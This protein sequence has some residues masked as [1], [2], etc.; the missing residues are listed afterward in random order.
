MRVHIWGGLVALWLGGA[1]VSCGGS[2]GAIECRDDTSC[3]RFPGGDCLVNPVTGNQFCTYPDGECPSGMRWS[4]LD[5]EDSISGT[6]VAV[7][8]GDDAGADSSVALDAG[9]DAQVAGTVVRLTADDG[10]AGDGFGH[11]AISGDTIAIGAPGDDDSAMNSGAVYIF[12]WNEGQ[13]VWEQTRKLKAGDPTSGAAFG[14]AVA[15]DGDVLVV[16]AA[17]VSNVG[18]A[19]VFERNGSGGWIQT[20]KLTSG[21][22]Y[23]TFGGAVATD[24]TIVVVGAPGD[25]TNAPQSGAVYAYRRGVSSWDF[26]GKLTDP[27]S[28]QDDKLGASVAVTAQWIVTSAPGYDVTAGFNDGA[29][30]VFET[31]GQSWLMKPRLVFPSSNGGGGFGSTVSV[32]GN[33]VAA[34]A[35]GAAGAGAVVLFGR[36]AG[37]VWEPT[38]TVTASNST[39]GA[40]FGAAVA[41]SGTTM[42]IGAIGVDSNTGTA[43]RFDRGVDAWA[44]TE[45]LDPAVVVP[46]AYFG[47]PVDADGS[48]IVIGAVFDT[49]STGAAYV[50]MY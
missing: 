43:Y 17:G 42:V 18:G 19:Y 31:A 45:F 32:S 44:E 28:I 4:D 33:V 40:K 34:G 11:V 25:D 3:D 20:P 12:E 27:D 37:G 10:E 8:S 23:D 22:N 14:G 15:L 36:N 21:A 6:C 1:V 49:S 46:G 35:Q 13:Q 38:Q 48:R 16:G 41:V 30:Y 7:S 50:V 2:S 9:V 29:V 39:S 47:A 26:K 5:V 24:G